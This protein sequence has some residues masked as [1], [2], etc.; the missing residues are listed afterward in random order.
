MYPPTARG[1]AHLSRSTILAACIAVLT[2][3]AACGGDGSSLSA[4]GARKSMSISF[5]TMPVAPAAAGQRDASALQRLIVPSASIQAVTGNDTLVIT[6]AQLVLSRV[7][8]TQTAGTPCDDDD[9]DAGCSEIERHFVVVDLPVDAT[10]QTALVGNIPAGTYTSLEARLRV[11]RSSDDAA[12][13]TFL[14]A[15]P[16]LTGANVRVEGTFRGA[17]FVY[18]GTVD[19]RFEIAFS[20]PIAVDSSGANVTVHVD[21]T[22]WF[23]DASGAL[24]D[25]ATASANGPNASR[26][27][28]NIV[29]SLRAVRDDERDGHDHG[30]DDGGHH[31][32]D[33]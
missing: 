5:A 20:P 12:A 2:L 32:S 1:T 8:L 9:G 21:L 22:T 10:V 27:A 24:L 14:A 28:G 11:P 33:H 13:T 4:P 3:T 30:G 18:L 19:T 7:E 16:E 25:P 6:R 23:R 17:P 26:V 29:R 15:H 31:G